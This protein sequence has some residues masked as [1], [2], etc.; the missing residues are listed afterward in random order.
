MLNFNTL[1]NNLGV[2]SRAPAPAHPA[3]EVSTL[4]DHQNHLGCLRIIRLQLLDW[5][6]LRPWIEFLNSASEDFG[7]NLDWETATLATFFLYLL[8]ETLELTQFQLPAL[9]NLLVYLIINLV[10]GEVHI[11]QYMYLPKSSMLNYQARYSCGITAL[12][13]LFW[14]IVPAW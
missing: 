10:S 13:H 6:R 1:C 9:F 12:G 2:P 5:F 11:C 3:S 7:H 14:R 8:L 4:A